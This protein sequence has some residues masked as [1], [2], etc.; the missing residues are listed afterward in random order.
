VRYIW[1]NGKR[2]LGKKRNECVEASRGDLIMH[3]DDDD[4][5][6]PHR[7]RYQAEALL[8]AGAEVCSV[9][10]M[11]FYEP[12][13][14]KTWLYSYTARQ[15]GWL[16][17]GTLLYT[18]DFWRRAPFPDMQVASDTRFVANRRLDRAVVLHRRAVPQPDS[19][20]YPAGRRGDHHRVYLCG[21]GQRRRARRRAARAG[22]SRSGCRGADWR[23][24]RR[25]APLHAHSPAFLL[26]QKV[27]LLP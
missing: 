9:T 13:T 20:R 27:R 16:A 22:R 17:G 14:G 18:R 3:W 5:H 23:E 4:W 24:H 11:L 19:A 1:L 15:L 2:T 25:R 6:A 12:A 10:Q 7:M 21:Y 26:P 8:H